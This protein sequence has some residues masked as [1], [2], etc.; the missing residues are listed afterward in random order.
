MRKMKR[1][2]AVLVAAAMAFS[3]GTAAFAEQAT[4]ETVQSDITTYADENADQAVNYSDT[5]AVD[6]SNNTY[7][8]VQAAI[9]AHNGTVG[10]L[11]NVSV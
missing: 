8:S 2:S 5:V 4:P 9:D 6:G 11:K 10:L 7:T 3:V 1:F